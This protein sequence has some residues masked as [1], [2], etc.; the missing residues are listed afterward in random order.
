MKIGAQLYTLRDYEKDLDSFA[1][2]L[3][4]VADIGYEYVQISGTCAFEADWMKAQLEKN[5]LKAPLTHT[6]RDKIAASTAEVIADHK[7]FG[8]DYI[9][10]GWYPLL[11][12]GT[13]EFID[14]FKPAAEKISKA[15]LF[16]SYH[17]HDFE[18][19]KGES[20]RLMFD[21]ILDAF[22]PEELKITLDTFWVQAGGANPMEWLDKLKGRTPCVHL[23]DMTYGKRMEVVGEGNMN[24]ERITKVC[25]D[26]GVEYA[27][28]EQDNCNGEDPFAC[29][30]RSYEYLKSLGLAK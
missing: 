19:A 10:I 4:K 18:F 8:A 28:V 23:K 11:E 12:K 21:E 22:T 25:V 24:F 17:N 3:S 30:K 7:V 27:F 1:D 29:L 14:T 15:G 9:G 2:T 13:R 16:L 6:D 5:G 26:N 20:G